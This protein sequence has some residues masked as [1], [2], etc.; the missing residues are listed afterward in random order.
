MEFCKA[1]SAF[2]MSNGNN[3]KYPMSTYMLKDILHFSKE[4]NCGWLSLFTAKC[5]RTHTYSDTE[6]SCVMYA[7]GIWLPTLDQEPNIRGQK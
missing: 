5:A 4:R 2:V 7:L 3:K 1:N 6:G